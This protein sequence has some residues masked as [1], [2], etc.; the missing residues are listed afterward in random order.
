LTDWSRFRNVAPVFVQQVHQE[1][2]VCG[3]KTVAKD[4]AAE[5]QG[6]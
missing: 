3:Q 4:A 1:L 6:G 2:A 5:R